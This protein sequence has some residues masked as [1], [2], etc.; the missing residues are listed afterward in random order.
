M[1]RPC[2]PVHLVLGPAI[3]VGWF[4]VLYA[5]MSVTCSLIPPAASQGAMTWIN[6]LLLVLTIL[7]T[8]LLTS[9]GYCCWRYASA[10]GGGWTDR[11]FTSRVAAGVYLLTAYSTLMIGMPVVFLPPCL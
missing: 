2:H 6:A 5:S 4:A 8:L 1:L 10:N 7:V 11:P 3:W 9:L